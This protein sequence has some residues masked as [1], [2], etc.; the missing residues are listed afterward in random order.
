MIL[1]PS[2]IYPFYIR[3]LVVSLWSTLYSQL[4]WMWNIYH[5][6]DIH[7]N[8]ADCAT[9]NLNQMNWIYI[10]LWWCS[11]QVFNKVPDFNHINLSIALLVGL[12]IF[13][14]GIETATDNRVRDFKLVD[15]NFI[16]CFSIGWLSCHS[17]LASLFF[18]GSIQLDVVWRNN[19]VHLAKFCLVQW[20]F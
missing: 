19:A 11:K 3:T 9:V 15:C 20:N 8:S 7:C 4:C 16:T 14:S 18:L 6:S 12:I 2:I 5:L 13:V 17:H 10:I 1:L